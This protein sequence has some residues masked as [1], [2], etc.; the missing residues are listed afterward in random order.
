MS[1]IQ[2]IEGHTD[3]F[4]E[5]EQLSAELEDRTKGRFTVRRSISTRDRNDPRHFMVIVFFDS[6]ESAMENSNLPET[7]AF[8]EQMMGLLAG[9]PKFHDLEVVDDKD[10]QDA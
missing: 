3:R 4:D 1:F 8:A 6:Y 5:I 2:V 9:P 10:F 7:Q